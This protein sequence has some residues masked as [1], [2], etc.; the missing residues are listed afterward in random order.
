MLFGTDGYLLGD[1]LLAAIVHG[2]ITY[3]VGAL[4]HNAIGRDSHTSFN[5]YN[6]TDD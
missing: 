4:E 5:G 3:N 2:L 6:I 1:S